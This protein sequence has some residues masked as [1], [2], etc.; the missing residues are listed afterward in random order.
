MRRLIDY[1]PLTRESVWY[2]YD[3]TSGEMILHHH[4]DVGHIIEAN[5][6][7]QNEDWY[8]KDG[9][10]KNMWHYA[11]IPNTVILKWKKEHGVDVFDKAH[12]RRMFKLLNDP[13]YKY[14]K[15]TTGTHNE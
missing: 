11:C 3:H 15:V 4:Q 5:K 10:K 14:L 7:R 13:E 2:D 9:I 1:D 8:S 12:R 6:M